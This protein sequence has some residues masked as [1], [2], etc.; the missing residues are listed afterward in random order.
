MET[1]VDQKVEESL[2]EKEIDQLIGNIPIIVTDTAENSTSV[3][4]SSDQTRS[5]HTAEKIKQIVTIETSKQ[6][7]IISQYQRRGVETAGSY[8]T[9]Q[10]ELAARF[11]QKDENSIERMEQR[12]RY[13]KL[14]GKSLI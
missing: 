4:A 11:N 5:N 7:F 13:Q 8:Q 1:V 10:E 9:V 12:H 14:D 3:V 2:E 6:E